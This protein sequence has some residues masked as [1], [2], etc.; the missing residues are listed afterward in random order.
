MQAEV[1][2]IGDELTSGQRLDTNSQWLSQRLGE[3]GLP[4]TFH[5]TVAD[6]L[7]ANVRAFR[8]AIERADVVVATGGLGPTADDLT[9]E[10]LAAVAGVELVL[11]ESVLEH[12]RRLFAL[13][14]RDMPERNRVQ[15]L[16]PAGSTMIPNPNGTAPGIF[17]TFEREGRSPC[18][19]F[20]LPGVPAEM[21][22][23][24]RASVAPELL[25]LGVADRI[26]MHRVIKCFGVGESHL[27][28]MLPDL[29]RRG[30]DPSVGITVSN[31]TISLRITSTGRTT[32]ECR[33]RIE[34][35][36]MTIYEC[37][38]DVIFGEGDDELEHAVAR[39]LEQR[40]KTLALVE[41]GTGGLIA[42][43]LS[44]VPEGAARLAGGLIVPRAEVLA[45][46]LDVPAS[47]IAEHSPISGEVVEAMARA[48]REK[49][50]ADLALAVSALPV[51]D[52][53][54]AEP[55]RVYFAVA[56][57]QKVTVRSAPYAGHPSIL[58]VRT[59]KQ[60]LNMLRLTLL[61]SG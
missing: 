52:R 48:G 42:H 2:S 1:I 15:A 16:F 32:D 20:A 34:P 51:L 45:E 18:H 13:F 46:L 41:W 56:D 4:V 38:K 17:M 22:E 44:E 58:K 11:D 7:D 25:R 6:A 26:L 49:T 55:P 23:M 40:D 36:A 28:E 50:R 33:A 14:Q 9:R 54:A 3:L 43:Q 39:L 5:T 10:A 27:E 59:A 21:H 60:A 61:R 31:A 29:I 47:L 30:R 12:I 53:T 24:W 35:T 19:L 37:L 8:E 57:E